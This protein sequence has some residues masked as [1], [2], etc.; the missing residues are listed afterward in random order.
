MGRS[1][2][3]RSE[4]NRSEINR[5]EI[6]RSENG[7]VERGT[8]SEPAVDAQGLWLRRGKVQALNGFDLV[9][10]A[11]SCHG[12][13]GRNGA[14][15]TS[16]LLSLL[17]LLRPD[18]GSVRI[19]GLDP[20]T[21]DTAVKSQVA[22]VP[23]NPAFYPWMT[24][25]GTLDYHASLRPTW[26]QDLEAH[27]LSKRFDLDPE[28]KV[29]A[30]SKGMRAQLAL[31]CALCADPRLLI[32]D[33]PTSGLDPVVRREVLETVIGEFLTEDRRRT[34]LIATHLIN[35]VEGIVDRFSLVVDGR[36]IWHDD[37]DEARA[38]FRSIRMEF[39]AEPPS[40]DMPEVVEVDRMGRLV[41]WVTDAFSDDLK[42]RLEALGPVS[43]ES[44]GLSLEE[45]FIHQ[46]RGR[47]A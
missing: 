11:G 29:S 12:L 9:V 6:N 28:A 24:V 43:M 13:F 16:A 8:E 26:N 41:E 44:R 30:L 18:R 14:G 46:C 7:R 34:V 45:I 2:M 33:E 23:D 5:S 35:E 31:A 21:S 38:R 32:L 36:S 20:V 4:M 39:N 22:F 17:N 47:V 27:L 37:T 42:A 25:R 10:P 15:K 19:Y 3:N 1:E 40:V